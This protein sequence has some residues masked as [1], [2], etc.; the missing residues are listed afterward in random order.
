MR[1]Y[2]NVFAIMVLATAPA[3][4]GVIYSTFGPGDS[5][6]PTVF[7]Y[8]GASLDVG[9]A[10]TPTATSVLTGI[11]VA[12]MGTSVGT[13]DVWIA[14][15]DGGVPGPVL[16]SFHFSP[17]SVPAPGTILSADSTL[18]PV[19]YSGSQY[20]IWADVHHAVWYGNYLGDG[21]LAPMVYRRSSTDP[22]VIRGNAVAPAYRINGEQVPEPGSFGLVLPAIGGLVAV[23]AYRRLKP[24]RRVALRR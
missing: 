15:D 23:G 8:G 9:S 21:I 18:N 24:R 5:Y 1:L 7:G 22:W 20:W 10:F 17:G 6:W 19:L 12:Y 3:G 16:D 2:R 14:A 4:A 11:D 13:L